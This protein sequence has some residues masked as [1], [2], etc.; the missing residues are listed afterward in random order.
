MPSSSFSYSGS[1]TNSEIKDLIR[2]ASRVASCRPCSSSRSSF[3]ALR[4]GV[5]ISLF[6]NPTGLMVMVIFF[7][8]DSVSSPNSMVASHSFAQPL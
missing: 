3:P 5:F 4:P 1:M 6:T 7:R 2:T 8:E